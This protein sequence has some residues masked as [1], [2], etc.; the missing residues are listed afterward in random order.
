MKITNK[1]IADFLSLQEMIKQLEKERDTIKAAI[2][3][4]GEVKV[5]DYTVAI[6]ERSREGVVGKGDL[7]EKLGLK[8]VEKLELLKTTFY[9]QVEIGLKKDKKAA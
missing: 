4:A 8:V 3:E 9:K 6:V 1:V 7:I 2:I 5:S